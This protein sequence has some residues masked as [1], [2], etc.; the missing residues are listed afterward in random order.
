M[1]DV[2]KNIDEYNQRKKKLLIVLHMID[3]N[4]KLI[5]KHF[6]CSY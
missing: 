3:G 2:H 4:K 1:Q 5:D 6:S